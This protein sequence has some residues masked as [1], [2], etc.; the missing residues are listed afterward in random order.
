[1]LIALTLATMSE[2]LGNLDVVSIFGSIALRFQEVSGLSGQENIFLWRRS[3]K[4]TLKSRHIWMKVELERTGPSNDKAVGIFNV[5]LSDH[6]LS[7]LKEEDSACLMWTKLDSNYAVRDAGRLSNVEDQSFRANMTTSRTAE[8]HIA[9]VNK[10]FSKLAGA[11]GTVTESHKGR[12]L[13]RSLHTSKWEK[14]VH[15][16]T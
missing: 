1:M 7:M 2:S 14:F 8:F 10:F 13:L 3:V 5:S 16:Q 4:A 11:G 6:V 9:K 15:L 12:K